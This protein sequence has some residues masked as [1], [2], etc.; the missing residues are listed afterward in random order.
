MKRDIFSDLMEGLEAL[1]DKRQGKVTLR[2]HTLKL[3]KRV[4]ITAEEAPA[5]E[6][7]TPPIVSRHTH[8]TKL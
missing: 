4:P 1:A 8:M 7:T 2:A 6:P 5:P 3:P